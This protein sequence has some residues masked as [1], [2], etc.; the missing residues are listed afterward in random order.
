MRIDV[1][2]GVALFNEINRP[3]R[4]LI[5]PHYNLQRYTVIDSGGHFPA[6]ENPDALVDEIRAF[7]RPLRTSADGT[8]VAARA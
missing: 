4:A 6:M 5:E 7:F 8:S 3:P 1:P 2:T